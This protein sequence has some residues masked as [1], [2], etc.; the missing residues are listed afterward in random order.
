M[1]NEYKKGRITVEG[2]TF[3]LEFWKDDYLNLPYVAASEITI[4]E[5]K[6]H[7]WSHKK[8]PMEVI[9]HIKKGWTTDNRIE[10][11]VRMINDYLQR[12]RDHAEE[13]H[14]IEALCRE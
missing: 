10:V 5:R 1:R 3:L 7:W 12:E 14:Q 9:H 4:E 11:G 8:E 6:P 13:D 2:R